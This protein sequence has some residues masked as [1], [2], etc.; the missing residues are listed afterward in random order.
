M[1][2]ISISKMIGIKFEEKRKKT[3]QS[4]RK[5]FADRPRSTSPPVVPYYSIACRFALFQAL[6]VM[7]HGMHDQRE[8]AQRLLSSPVSDAVE[9]NAVSREQTSRSHWTA[10]H[11]PVALTCASRAFSNS[12][13]SS[14]S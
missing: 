4:C 7:R 6:R 9:K 12:V 1:A 5:V 8:V 2:K 13:P 3:A 10:G 14:L 11:A